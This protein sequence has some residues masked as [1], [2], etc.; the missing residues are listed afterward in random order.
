MIVKLTLSQIELLVD[1]LDADIRYQ[2]Q[3]N[4]V[5]YKA[6]TNIVSSDSEVVELLGLYYQLKNLLLVE[7]TKQ[8]QSQQQAQY[9]GERRDML[10]D[11]MLIN[12]DPE[13][14][15]ATKSIQSKLQAVTKSIHFN[16]EIDVE[17]DE[18]A[19]K[20]LLSKNLIN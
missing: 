17:L 13:L 6:G 16:A 7:H 12:A 3:L 18:S 11:Y 10:F 9:L 14:D 5:A 1:N 20:L 4:L 8:V 2:H 15:T 19:Y